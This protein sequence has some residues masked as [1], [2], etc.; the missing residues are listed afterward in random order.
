MR[1]VGSVLRPYAVALLLALVMALV[2][3]AVLVAYGLPLRNPE[4]VE[5][6]AF[7]R[8]PAAVALMVLIDTVPRALRRRTSLRSVVAERYGPHR[9]GLIVVGFGA[10]YLCYVAYR[11]LKAALPLARPN[12]FDTD[13]S[14]LDRLLTFGNDPAVLLHTVLGTGISAHLL[15]AVYLGFLGLVPVSVAVALVWNRNTWVGAWYVTA[16]C[17]NW[18]GGAL[19][20]YLVPSLGPVFDRAQPFAALPHTEVAALYQSLASDRLAVIADPHGAGV[21]AG[22][23]G[24][25]SLHVSLTFTAAL[26]A[27]RL[28]LPRL[29]RWAAWAFLVLTIVSTLYFGWHYIADDLAGLGLGLVAVV[30]AQWATRQHAAEVEQ[31]V[32]EPVEVSS[33]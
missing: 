13:L 5:G 23:A 29:V 25:A 28:A 24:F 11:N 7:V 17:V 19:S 33:R 21:M 26:V 22:V 30:V 9:L 4:G 8:V 31:A 14:A 3:V 1:F 15:S 32:A 2:A 6:P 27:H 16:M 10:F 18:V 20:Y 12:L